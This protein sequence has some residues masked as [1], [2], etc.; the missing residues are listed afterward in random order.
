M[1]EAVSLVAALPGLNQRVCKPAESFKKTGPVLGD[2]VLEEA[3]TCR[4]PGFGNDV[5]R[6]NDEFEDTR[7][8]TIPEVEVPL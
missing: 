8:R 5:F 6:D 3:A 7:G 4:N 2:C 1:E